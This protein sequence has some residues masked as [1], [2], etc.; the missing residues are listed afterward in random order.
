[1][2]KDL[3]NCLLSAGDN[4]MINFQEIGEIA[5]VVGELKETLVIYNRIVNELTY[6]EFISNN[7]DA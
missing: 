6:G 5:F 4:M 2:M 1:M 7:Y 3:G